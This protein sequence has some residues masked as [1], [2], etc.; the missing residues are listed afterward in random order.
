VQNGIFVSIDHGQTWKKIP[1][2]ERATL[3]SSLYWRT[4]DEIIVSTYGRGLW[5]AKFKITS[6]AR[7]CS[8]PDCTHVYYERPPKKQPSPYD[9]TIS[10]YG[11]QIR[12]VRLQDGILQEIFVQ[13]GTSL[14]YDVGTLEAPD[15]LVTETTASAPSPGGAALPA[16]PA[17]SPFITGLTLRNAGTGTELVGVMFSPRP[18]SMFTPPAA[19]PAVITPSHPAPAWSGPTLEVLSGLQTMPGEPIRLKG[20]GLAA[21]TEVEI[22]LDGIT[23]LK[24]TA[25]ADGTFEASLTAPGAFGL[26]SLTMLVGGR[27]VNGAILGVRPGE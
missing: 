10:A 26:H 4:F 15:V 14:E 18:L 2:S 9:F 17:G 12:G 21:G 13:P 24:V 22:Q 3:I 16:A 23:V 1:G 19:G 11:G 20:G 8:L 25:G 5:R 7:V 27:P 6:G